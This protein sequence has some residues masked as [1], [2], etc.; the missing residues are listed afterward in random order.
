M[1]VR[2][3]RSLEREGRA[4][5]GKE[6]KEEEEVVVQRLQGG[7][8]GGAVGLVRCSFPATSFS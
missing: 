5:G 7:S 4:Y 1:C 6:E 8:E 3:F 2:F